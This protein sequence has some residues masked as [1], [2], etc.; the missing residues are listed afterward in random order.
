MTCVFDPP[1]PVTAPTTDGHLFPV[2]R[3][4]CVGRNYA[5]HAREMGGDPNREPPFFFTAWAE[6]VVPDGT[7]IAWPPGTDDYHHEVE[8]VVA[9]G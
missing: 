4:F 6:T 8:L 9:I 7:V 3:V 5:D 2:R 1:V